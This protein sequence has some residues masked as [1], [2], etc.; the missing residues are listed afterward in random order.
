MRA[1]D[2]WTHRDR[3]MKIERSTSND[4]SSSHAMWKNLDGSSWIG[5]TRLKEVDLPNDIQ[6]ELLI[7]D[8]TTHPTVT[9]KFSYKIKMFIDGNTVLGFF[10]KLNCLDTTI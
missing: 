10:S 8:E 3:S 4:A 7:K 2:T 9:P 1:M 6:S 5:H